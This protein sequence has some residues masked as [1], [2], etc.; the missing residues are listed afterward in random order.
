MDPQEF[1]SDICATH[2]PC[3]MYLFCCRY[4][5]WERIDT[6]GGSNSTR[7]LLI[8]LYIYSD[9]ISRTGALRGSIKG[10]FEPFFEC[11][12]RFPCVLQLIKVYGE[13]SHSRSVWVSPSATARDV[14]HMLVQT[15]HC[16]DQ[17]NW[18]LLEVRPT[19]GL[20]KNTCQ[21]H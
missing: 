11:L 9:Y 14:C 15:A 17:E 3:T 18:A 10:C 2:L 16:S 7:S 12:N 6:V 13:D 19:L 20:G 8:I 4:W 5:N 1:R 21:H